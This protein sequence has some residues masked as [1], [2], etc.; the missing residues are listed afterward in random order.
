MNGYAPYLLIVFFLICSAFFSGSEIA[1]TS[2]NKGRLKKHAEE[3]NKKAQVACYIAD[4]FDKALSTILIGNNLVNIASS[5]VSTMIAIALVG[6]ELGTTLAT[7]VMTI[8]LLIFGEITPK[9]VAKETNEKFS[10]AVA[11]LLRLLMLIFAPVVWVTVSVVNVIS[12]IWTKDVKEEAGMTEDELL[13]IIETV[14]DEGVIDENQSEL[15]QSALE[16]SDIAVSEIVVPRVDMVAINADSTKEQV[17]STAIDAHFSRMPVYRKSIDNIIGVLPVNALL[18]QLTNGEEMNI[19][20]VLVDVCFVHKSMKLPAVLDELKRK[21]THLAI[22]TDEY[23][24]TMGLV[25]MEDI[26]EQLVG[27]IWDESDEI[28]AEI[29]EVSENTYDVSG[30]MNVYDFLDHL[31]LDDKDF[32]SE[33]TT[34]GGWA[35]E[36]LEGNPSENDSFVYENITVTVKQMQD[37]RVTQL[38]VVVVPVE[39]DEEEF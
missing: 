29:V 25:T 6:E 37:M 19:E 33:Y 5:S 17:L 35:I 34:V 22:V 1:Y 7:I 26:L 28:I 12:K 24:G 21:K 15:L 32:E 31:E 27:D 4:N 2:V 18:K 11:R 38:E 16:F 9:I 14:E 23:G 3:G 10:L 13:T 8:L 20:S 39:D 36:M 30:D